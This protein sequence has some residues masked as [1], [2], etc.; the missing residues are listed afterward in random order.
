MVP[1]AREIQK[2]LAERSQ[3]PLPASL[4]REALTNFILLNNTREDCM[5][6]TIIP[7]SCPAATKMTSGDRAYLHQLCS[8]GC[9]CDVHLCDTEFR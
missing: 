8:P 3:L 7:L 4:H 5:F 1:A 9:Q 2:Y 6:V